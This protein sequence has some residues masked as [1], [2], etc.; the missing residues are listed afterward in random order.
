KAKASTQAKNDA[1]EAS[2]EASQEEGQEAQSA[3]LCETSSSDH[4]KWLRCSPKAY[5]MGLG[6]T[7]IILL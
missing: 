6:K 3:R 2:Q 7:K 1:V 5:E 4:A